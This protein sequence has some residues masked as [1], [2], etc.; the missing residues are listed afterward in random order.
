M[1][2]GW[3]V[4]AH[5]RTDMVLDALEM[6]RWSRMMSY[7]ARILRCMAVCS[8][9]NQEMRIAASCSIEVMRLDGVGYPV[10]RHTGK[11]RCGDCGVMPRGAHH[12]GCDMARCPRCKRQLLTCGCWFDEYGPV[13]G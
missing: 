10:R 6:A 8:E 2:V 1:I 13:R 11:A 4:A 9:C 12:L 5:M 7:P 3:R